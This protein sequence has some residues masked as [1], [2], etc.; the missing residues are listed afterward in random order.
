MGRRGVNRLKSHQAVYAASRTVGTSGCAGREKV[1][2]PKRG[3]KLPNSCF[4]R[5]GTSGPNVRGGHR[6]AGL[7]PG[8][9]FR[10]G[11]R[12]LSQ[13]FWDSWD[14]CT[15]RTRTDQFGRNKGL[16]F[17]TYGPKVRM[18]REKPKEPRANRILPRVFAAN[19]NKEARIRRFGEIF[20]RRFGTSGPKV[21]E[22]H[23]GREKPKNL[24]TNQNVP[25]VR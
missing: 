21:R 13:A 23:V 3:K 5:S 12:Y 6:S 24:P 16:S 14:K 20:P 19:R 10:A 9:P 7:A 4:A 17:G 22:G 18:G 2:W 11:R 25:R 1:N 15:R 8:S